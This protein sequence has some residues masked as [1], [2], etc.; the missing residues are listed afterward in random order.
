ML[1]MNQIIL[2][3]TDPMATSIDNIDMQIRQME[4]YRNRLNQLQMQ[5]QNI[6]QRLI[7]DDIDAEVNPLSDEQKNKLMLDK[8]YSDTYNAIQI[9]V[10]NEILNLVKSRIENTDKGKELLS[11][12]LSIIKKLKTKI[13]N[14]T[15]IEMEMF[16]KFKE[17]SKNNP[18]VTYEEF[19]K[20]GI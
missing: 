9:L 6:S 13:I 8:E 1:P 20:K 7:W 19:I 15:N 3:N 2:G 4:E 10:Q 11:K 12:Q 16:K 5:K 18:T 17:Y 14:D